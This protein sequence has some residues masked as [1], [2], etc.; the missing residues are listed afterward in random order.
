MTEEGRIILG[1]SDTSLYTQE[2]RQFI[3]T[4]DWPK[5]LILDVFEADEPSPHLN[6]IFYRDNWLTLEF[7]Q[8]Q[9]VVTIVQEVM[10]K[11][12]GDGIPTYVGKMERASDGK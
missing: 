11:L 12:W 8:Q 7:A 6:I 9:Q 1:T 2:V 10:A 3:R 4:R 5:G